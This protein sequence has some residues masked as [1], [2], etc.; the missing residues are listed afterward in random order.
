MLSVGSCLHSS[1]YSHSCSRKNGYDNGRNGRLS[2][3]YEYKCRIFQQ[4][5]QAPVP[6]RP[7]PVRTGGDKFRHI[8]FQF[9]IHF[10]KAENATVNVRGS[11]FAI[12]SKVSKWRLL[13]GICPSSRVDYHDSSSLISSN[14]FSCN[15]KIE[16]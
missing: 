15:L 11:T 14:F 9:F 3:R 4:W 10:H 13:D 8:V 16:W 6:V 7:Y 1:T 12:C 5:S 2:R